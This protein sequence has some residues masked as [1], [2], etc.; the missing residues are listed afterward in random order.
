IAREGGGIAATV[1]STRQADFDALFKASLPRVKRLLN[2]G[3]TTLEIKSGYGLE[4]ATEKRMLQVARALGQHTGLDVLTT[5]LGAHA[6][7]PGYSGTAD[8]YINHISQRDLP[9]LAAE[10]L[11]DAVDAFCETIGFTRAQTQRLFE[12]AKKLGLPVKLHA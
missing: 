6:L 3:V 7:P 1:K 9:Q 8:D 11:V 12:A 2:E 5:Y 10:G 4:L